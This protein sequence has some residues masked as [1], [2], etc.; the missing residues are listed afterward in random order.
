MKC[1]SN[2]SEKRT[3]SEFLVKFLKQYLQSF[4]TTVVPL[5]DLIVVEL[6][7]SEKHVKDSVLM[8][9]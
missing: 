8:I 1:A 4:D 2:L 6:H 5:L 7:V 9:L 3:V